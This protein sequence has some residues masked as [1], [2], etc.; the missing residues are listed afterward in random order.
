MTFVQ[1][2]GILFRKLLKIGTN[3]SFGMMKSIYCVVA[4]STKVSML[5]S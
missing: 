2:I 3:N 4:M 1:V 5:S